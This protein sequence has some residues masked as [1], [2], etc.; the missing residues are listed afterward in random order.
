[1]QG[2]NLGHKNGD[3]Q[4]VINQD[5]DSVSCIDKLFEEAWP[6]IARQGGDAHDAVVDKHIKGNAGDEL[7]CALP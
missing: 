4:C 7:R 6:S 2:E 1:M 3:H 5:R